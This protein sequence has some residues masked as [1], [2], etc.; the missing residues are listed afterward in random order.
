MAEHTALLKCAGCITDLLQHQVL[1]ISSKLLKKGLT[2]K[3]VH[4]WMLTAKGV[5]DREK[6]ARLMSGVIDHVRSCP[7][8]YSVFVGIL[9]EDHFFKEAIENL[10]SEYHSMSIRRTK[11]SLT[12]S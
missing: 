8:K 7:E 5:S 12:S 2:T 9:K 6:A 3:E 10:S 11:S 1:S 4:G